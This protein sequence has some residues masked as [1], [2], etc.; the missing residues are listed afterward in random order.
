MSYDLVVVGTSY[1]GLHALG[2]LLEGLP[3]DFHP[4]VAVVQHR[5]KDSDLTLVS[6]LSDR[7]IREVREAEDKEP[8]EP[9]RIYVAPPDYHL[10]VEDGVFG[11]S[12]EAPVTFSR[13]S[14]DVLFETAADAY[15]ERLIGVVLTG[16]N[17]DGTAGL[18]RIK[19]QG[20]YA[21]VQDPATAAGRAMPAAAVAGVRADAV[22]PLERIAGHLVEI[23]R[24]TR[25]NP[26]GRRR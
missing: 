13:P 25:P 10:L 2:V 14:I 3:A 4:A 24:S 1:G 5:S 12:T 21:I 17:A 7:S 18:K 20:G 19:D 15:R 22:L 16:A 26:A 6:L 8:I 23:D 11:L 9:G